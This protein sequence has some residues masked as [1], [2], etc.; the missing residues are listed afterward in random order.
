MRKLFLSLLCLVAFA[1]HAQSI[2]FNKNGECKIV[3]F[4]DIHYKVSH[5]ENSALSLEVIHQTLDTEKP[6]VVL[7]TG[8]IVTGAP[9]EQG[10]KEV[11]S[12]MVERN[13]PFAVTFGNHDDESGVS[14]RDLMKYIR[15]FKGCL[16]AGIGD[17]TNFDGA[18]RVKGSVSEQTKAALYLFDSNSYSTF[19]EVSGYGWLKPAQVEA[20]NRL[21]ETLTQENAGQPLP[22]LAFLHIPLPEY[23]QAFNS[24]KST[25]VGERLETE[26]PAAI[27]TGLYASMKI[28]GDVMGVFC[29][30]DHNN[31]YLADMHGIAMVYG[32]FTGSKNTYTETESGARIITL[33]EGLHR[34]ETKVRLR[35]GKEIGATTYPALDVKAMTFNMRFDHQGDGENRWDNRK[36]DVVNTIRDFQVDLLGTQELLDHQVEFLKQQLSGFHQV[37]VGRVDG[38][39]AGEYTAIYYNRHRFK[40]LKSGNFWLS[41]HPEAVGVKGWDAACERLATWVLLEDNRS[42][43]T[44]F[45]INTHFDHVGK[46]AQSESAKL[47][48]RKIRELKGAA[49]AV[50]VT[51]DFNI[52]PSHPAIAELQKPDKALHLVDSRAIATKVEGPAWSF[53]DFG[54]LDDEKRPLIDYVFVSEGAKVASQQVIFQA[55][56][57]KCVS[58]HTPVLSVIEF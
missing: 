58:D 8:D 28:N 18:I 1:M 3:Q 41:K 57:K 9:V 13:I 36:Y 10:W 43:K 20:Y 25:P 19:D 15:T 39:K 35:S 38:E 7:L 2:R 6:E 51:G 54:R 31:D 14:R 46:K 55:E 56:K 11:L 16:N 33:K 45:F 21:S 26:C 27:N 44:L 52:I 49:D 4:T 32:R 50:L 34:F 42:G 5:P 37:G 22:A 24:K 53:H 48:K 12:P 17:E 29:G 30:H 47:L 23:S 40:E